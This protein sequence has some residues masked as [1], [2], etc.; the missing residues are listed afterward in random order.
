MYHLV[1]ANMLGANEPM[2]VDGAAVSA[3]LFPTLGVQPLI[4]RLFVDDDDRAERRRHGDPEL[5]PLADALWRR[6]GRRSASSCRSTARSHT[7]IGVMP[8]EFRFPTPDTQLWTPLRFAEE[9]YVDRND[10][11]MYAVG[12]LRDGVTLEQAR[13]EMELIAARFSQAVPEGERQ[14]VG[15]SVVRFERRR[16]AAVAAAADRAVRRSGMRP[17]HRLRQPRQPA[18]RARARAP[19]R[20]GG[21]HGDGRGPRANDPPADDR[22]PAAR[23]HRRR[24]RRRGRGDGGAAA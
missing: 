4:G 14:G 20:A 21:S 7:V 3:D 8:R 19:A 13:A 12:R 17:A 22:E 1:S 23:R 15:A 2:R 9:A 11:W 18:A 16:A 10:N 6:S 5:P 24:A